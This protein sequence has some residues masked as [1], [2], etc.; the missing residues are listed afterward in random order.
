MAIPDEF[1]QELKARSDIVDVVSSYVNLKKSGRNMLGICPFHN[2]KTASFNVSRENGFFYCFGCHAGG[3][4]ITFIKKIENLDYVDAIKFLAQRAGM[5]IPEENRNEGLS[6]LKN[7][8]YEANREAARFYHKQLYTPQGQKALDYLRKRQ[9]SE[10]TIIH[11]GL[12]YSPPSRFELV[13]YLKSK[14]FSGTELIAANLANES[15]NGKPFDRFSDRVMFPIIDLRGNVIA[16]GGRIMSDIK[17]K[18][19][20]TSDTPVF[21]KSHNLFALQFAKNKA[22]GQLILVEGYM[23]V[24]AL[25][26][27]GF[28][29]AIA[30]LGT[31]LTQEQALIIKRYCDEVVICYDADEAGQKA[32]ARA[33]SILR[34]TGLNIKVLTVPDGKDPDEY[35]KSHGEQGST[36]FRMLLEKCGNDV[37]YRLQKLRMNYNTDI[38]QQRV[39]FLTESAKIIASL[40]NSI[41]Q[42]IY[43][44][45]LAQGLN[46]EKNAI[47][48]QVSRYNRQNTRQAAKKEQREIHNSISAIND[49]INTEKSY[50]LR[51]ANAEEALIAL[52]IFNP[53]TANTICSKTPP[54]KFIT[55]FNRKV[56]DVIRTRVLEGKDI[57][58]TDISGEFSNDEMSQIAKILVAHPRENDSLRA[59]EEY[60]TVLDE[61]ANKLTP[62]QI[63][64]AD[65]QTLMEQLRKM[66]EKKK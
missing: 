23:D 65:T 31:S 37:E 1:I 29:N 42:D 41:E 11:F 3:D 59:A 55:S 28:E 12:G 38:T 22:N 26:Q 18:Y 27:A 16:F 64:Q 40:D 44:S 58:L 20:N 63:A 53:D 21:S 39:E 43:I 32:T 50:N 17:P 48:Q 62:E 35:I 15:R 33:I 57:S 52:L 36:R 4:V 9:L 54:E 8:I 5:T 60:L 47:R 30:T 46:V 66:K 7:R 2:E 13:N 34:P 6:R 25:H 49:K 51:A 61:E 45:S 10:K 19:L 56:Y 24:I 14:G